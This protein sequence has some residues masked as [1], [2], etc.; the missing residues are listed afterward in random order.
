MQDLATKLG[1]KE[2]VRWLDY[3]VEKISGFMR[4]S[5]KPWWSILI[6][7][8]SIDSLNC[9]YCSHIQS[10]MNSCLLKHWPVAQDLEDTDLGKQFLAFELCIFSKRMCTFGC[11]FQLQLRST[12]HPKQLVCFSHY[13]LISASDSDRRWWSQKSDYLWA[14]ESSFFAEPTSASDGITP[15]NEL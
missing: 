1:L 10:L 13:V 5:M 2:T 8:G 11:Q 15:I 6:L 9:I 14:C 3:L 12:W 7:Y 4:R